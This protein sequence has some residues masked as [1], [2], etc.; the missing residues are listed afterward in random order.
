MKTTLC[1]DYK[2]SFPNNQS[3]DIYHLYSAP[4]AILNATS[5]QE[6]YLGKTSLI[7]CEVDRGSPLANIHWLHVQYHNETGQQKLTEI[8]NSSDPRFTIVSD[9]LQIT[10]VQHSD[11]GTYRC[12]VYNS[13]GTVFRDIHAVIGGLK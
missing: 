4:P 7:K 3:F 6:I 9:G 11:D 5:V 8:T 13:Y 12:Y 1:H 2:L 10:N